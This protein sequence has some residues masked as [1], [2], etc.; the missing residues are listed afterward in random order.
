MISE[1]RKRTLIQLAVFLGLGLI[2]GLFSWYHNSKEKRALV[3]SKAFGVGTIY[4]VLVMKSRGT[5]AYYDFKVG[6]G[7]GTD[8]RYEQLGSLI[9]KRSFPVIYDSLDPS[10]CQILVFP[11]NFAKYGLPFPDSL[12]WVIDRLNE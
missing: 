8:A 3:R 11:D 2:Y 7:E 9:Y 6:D 10:N 4:R 5:V 1:Q 12:S